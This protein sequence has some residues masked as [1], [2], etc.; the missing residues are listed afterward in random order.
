MNYVGLEFYKH[1]VY[2][3]VL[4]EQ[5]KIIK[6]GTCRNKKRRLYSIPS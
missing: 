4:T 2:G 3:M 5:E 1:K 6:E